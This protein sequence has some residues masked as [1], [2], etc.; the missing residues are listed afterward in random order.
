MFIEITKINSYGEKGVALIRVEDIQGI[1]EHHVESEKL[2]D[3]NGNVVQETP[4]GRDFGILVVTERG[5][6]EVFHVDETEYQRV[7]GILTNPTK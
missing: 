5:N 1:K 2:Y 7:K 3:E 4:K 6:Q